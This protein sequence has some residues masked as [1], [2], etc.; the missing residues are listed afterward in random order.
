[1]WEIDPILQ[2]SER[3][4]RKESLILQTQIGR[5]KARLKAN[6]TRH[7]NS[8]YK[9]SKIRMIIFKKKIKP[10]CLHLHISI[11]TFYFS[12]ALFDFITSKYLFSQAMFYKVALT[13]LILAVKTRESQATLKNL[14]QIVPYAFRSQ[15]EFNA[16]EKKFLTILNFNL[17]VVTVFDIISLLASKIEFFDE[18]KKS[19]IDHFK[20]FI[21][22]I[23]FEICLNY[24]AN[25]FQVI[26]MAL[27]I[28]IFARETFNC[29]SL[30]H[31]TFNTWFELNEQNLEKCIKM[32]RFYGNKIVSDLKKMKFLPML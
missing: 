30:L 26:A 27:S 29:N 14:K 25:R 19:E 24:S 5:V 18:I 3:N 21:S 23:C 28:F 15:L 13:C 9:H 11:K 20:I 6:P 10:L 16:L 2:T 31:S 1:M 22:R 12:L 17:N 8:S 32:V 4:S 7:Y